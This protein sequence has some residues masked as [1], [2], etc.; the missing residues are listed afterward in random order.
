MRLRRAAALLETGEFTVSEVAYQVGFLD[1]SHF[2]ASFKKQYQL[3]PSQY[4]NKH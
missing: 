2:S 4:I 3:T 1:M